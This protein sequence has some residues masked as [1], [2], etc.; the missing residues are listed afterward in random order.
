MSSLARS[1]IAGGI[2]CPE[3]VLLKSHVLVMSFIGR[4]G[5]FVCL[6]FPSRLLLRFLALFHYSLAHPLTFPVLLPPA[7]SLARAAPRLK[8]AEFSLEKAEELYVECIK[9]MR[10]LYQVCHLVHADFSEYNIL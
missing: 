6:Q 10:R 7:L 3:P 9:L 2:P 1:L 5:W 4:D 8:D